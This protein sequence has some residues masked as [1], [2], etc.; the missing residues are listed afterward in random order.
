MRRM[1]SA[2]LDNDVYSAKT[3]SFLRPVAT[4]AL[5]AAVGHAASANIVN[6]A[7]TAIRRYWFSCCTVREFALAA[8]FGAGRILGQ[9][10]CRVPRSMY[11]DRK[12]QGIS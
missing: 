2:L 3:T 8:R 11:R 7:Q 9:R 12:L 10:F 5:W 4:A 6:A 1:I